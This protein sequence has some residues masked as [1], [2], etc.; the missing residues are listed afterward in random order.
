MISVRKILIITLA[1]LGLALTVSYYRFELDRIAE[2]RAAI[3]KSEAEL[4][5]KRE[6]VRI[7]REKAAFYKTQEGIE[8]L[9]REQYN[10][11]GDKERVFLLVSPDNV[12]NMFN[13]EVLGIDDEK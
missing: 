10:L 12:P 2:I 9:A 3:V 11:V 5:R 6:I 1:V 13:D 8:H 7:Y 4:E